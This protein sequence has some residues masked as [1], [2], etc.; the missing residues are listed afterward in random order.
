MTYFESYTAEFDHE[1]A[2]T[3]RFLERVPDSDGDWRPHAKSMSLKQL[4]GHLATMPCHVTAVLTRDAADVADASWRPRGFEATRA[5]W[6][7][8]FDKAVAEAR[9]ALQ[10][11][12]DADLGRTWTLSAGP[13]KIFSLPRAAALRTF[14]MNHMVHHRAQL[15]VYLRLKDVPV[16]GTYGPSADEALGR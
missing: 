10:T 11:A 3:R 1:M 12:K 7:A 9:Q 14:A 5:S 2:I 6:L 13:Q 15:G 8:V 4:A 16:P